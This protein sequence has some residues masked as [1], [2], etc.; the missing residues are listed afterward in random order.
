[1]NKH[2]LIQYD[3]FDDDFEQEIED[4][5]DSFLGD[6]VSN[7]QKEDLYNSISLICRKYSK[8]YLQ[9]AKN[10]E[11]FPPIQHQE[12]CKLSPS[13]NLYICSPPSNPIPPPTSY[14]YYQ[15]MI[16]PVT[17][18]SPY[19]I[20]ISQPLQM[21]PPPNPYSST[22]PPFL[23]TTQ[24]NKTEKSKSAKKKHH[25]EKSKSKKHKS[26]SHSKSS[27][28]DK[29]HKKSKKDK[30]AEIK[31]FPYK[32][33]IELNG[34]IKYLTDKTGGNINDN[35]TIEISSNNI[36]SGGGFKTYHP[37]NVLNSIIDDDYMAND[38]KTAY[39]RFDF[40]DKM[41]EVSNYTVRNAK[42]GGKIKNWVFEISDD[43][44]N[45]T[46]IDKRSNFIFN[47]KKIW[48][49][50]VKNKR[51]SRYCQ[52]RHNGPFTGMLY[53]LMINAI[54]L[55]GKLKTPKK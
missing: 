22:L 21:I 46:E 50:D 54:E 15:P 40:K 29:D 17:Q 10:D 14:N 26:S 43:G 28:S 33:G 55:Y 11:S 5:V 36:N 20:P 49:I 48:T 18:P 42:R 44:N 24:P 47:D 52:L 35:G 23:T 51:F 7:S 34:I 30:K 32:E 12:P 39:I 8:N 41:V 53:N 1:M 4:I 31:S 27:K 19:Q 25:S 38:G 16:A 45:W 6:R 2:S 9:L 13:I 37:K 3:Q